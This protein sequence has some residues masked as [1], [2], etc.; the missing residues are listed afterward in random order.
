MSGGEEYLKNQGD[1]LVFLLDNKVLKAYFMNCVLVIKI[2][3]SA[4]R[5]FN[6]FIQI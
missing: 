3:Y 4:E 6:I 5:L 2:I 1:P